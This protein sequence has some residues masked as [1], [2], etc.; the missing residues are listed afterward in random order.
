MNV[1]RITIILVGLLTLAGCGGGEGTSSPPV[2]LD[3]DLEPLESA[4]T[5]HTPEYHVRLRQVLR[6]KAPDDSLLQFLVMPSF[7]P[8][9]QLSLHRVGQGYEVHIVTPRE[10]IWYSKAPVDQIEC[11]EARKGLPAATAE[12]LREVWKQMLR[13]TRYSE[14][15]PTTLDGTSYAF[16]NLERGPGRDWSGRASNPPPGT[17]PNLLAQIGEDVIAYVRADA[18][19]EPTLLAKVDSAL[20]QLEASLAK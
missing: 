2:T 6:K 1:P 16:L 10:Q 17:R 19:A 9:T 13:R 4:F 18:S 7:E 20:A 3:G 14:A 8:E 5:Y 15:P 11:I 12:R